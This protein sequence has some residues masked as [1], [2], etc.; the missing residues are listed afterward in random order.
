MILFKKTEDPR[1]S[2]SY[3]DSK[4]EWEKLPSLSSTTNGIIASYITH[5]ENKTTTGDCWK[6]IVIEKKP[7]KKNYAKKTWRKQTQDKRKRVTQK[8][9]N[10]NDIKSQLTQHDKKLVKAVEQHFFFTSSTAFI[11]FPRYSARRKKCPYS[12]FIWSAFFPHCGPELCG[13][14][15]NCRKNFR[16]LIPDT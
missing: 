6:L 4:L 9:E 13:A 2:F 1:F 8:T 7:V 12:E 10:S 14:E 15:K 3:Y 16:F 11:H 5:P